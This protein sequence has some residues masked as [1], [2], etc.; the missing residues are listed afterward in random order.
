MAGFCEQDV[1]IRFAWKSGISLQARYLFATEGR[2]F[3]VE[4]IIYVLL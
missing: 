1:E 4:L 2:L 3:T